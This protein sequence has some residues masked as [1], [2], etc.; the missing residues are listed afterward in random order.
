MD[1]FSQLLL[2]ANE[3]VA[4]LRAQINGL[5]PAIEQLRENAQNANVRTAATQ[6]PQLAPLEHVCPATAQVGSLENRRAIDFMRDVDEIVWRRS[7]RCPLDSEMPQNPF[8]EENFAA[9]LDR[10]KLWENIS[11]NRV[12]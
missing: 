5:R 3:G 9:L 8:S 4:S 6:T 2:Q 12:Y 7:S 11:R 10:I 1:R